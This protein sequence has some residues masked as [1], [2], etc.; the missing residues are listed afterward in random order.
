MRI[1]RCVDCSFSRAV[2][3]LISPLESAFYSVSDLVQDGKRFPNQ[4][5]VLD[6]AWHTR[7]TK[8]IN[9]LY[10][11]QN[12]LAYEPLMDSTIS[13]LIEKLHERFVRPVKACDMDNW[14]HYCGS[15]RH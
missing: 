10:S 15:P 1:L 6:E 7:T 12:V 13:E 2:T 9:K 8:P 3:T 5:S 11:L 14:L 4:F